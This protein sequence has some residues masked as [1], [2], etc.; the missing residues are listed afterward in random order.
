MIPSDEIWIKI[1]GDK[2][3][4]SFKTSLQVVNVPKPNSVRNS[5][6]FAVFEAPDIS[7]NLHIALKQYSSQMTELQASNWKLVNQKIQCQ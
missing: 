5:C 3:G 1:G 4:T 6:A 7:A 2:G